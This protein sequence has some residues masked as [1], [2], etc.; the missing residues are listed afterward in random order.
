MNRSYSVIF[1]NVSIAAAQDL[2][3]ITP[4]DDKPICIVGFTLSNVGG[5][6]DAADAQEELLRLTIGRGNTTNGTG[7]TTPTPQPLNA[8]EAAAGFTSRV[9]DA[10]TRASGGARS[11]LFADGWNVRI[12]YQMFFTPE[13]GIWCSQAQTLI[14]IGLEAAPA[15]P[16]LCSGTLFVMET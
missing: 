1:D 11:V 14:T 6:A 9:N 8:A 3:N 2:F 4:A 16:V 13:T 7:G 12:P 15:D 5:T 10:T